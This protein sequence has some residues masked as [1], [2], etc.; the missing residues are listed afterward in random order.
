MKRLTSICSMYCGKIWLLCHLSIITFPFI[1]FW[2]IFPLLCLQRCNNFNLCINRLQYFCIVNLKLNMFFDASKY[3]TLADLK[4][5]WRAVVDQISKLKR[6]YKRIETESE[7][8]SKCTDSTRGNYWLDSRLKPQD[9][10]GEFNNFFSWSSE[11]ARH[12]SE[13]TIRP[14]CNCLEWHIVMQYCPM[15]NYHYVHNLWQIVR[16]DSENIYVLII[17]CKW[18]HFGANC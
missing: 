1:L 9:S 13:N 12:L 2:W 8:S 10:F 5:M 4:R 18:K 6:R 11:S 15:A 17:S 3:L 16:G 7:S 14:S